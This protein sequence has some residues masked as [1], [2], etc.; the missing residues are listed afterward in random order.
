M[1]RRRDVFMGAT[2][3]KTYLAGYGVNSSFVVGCLL[4]CLLS[5]RQ[6]KTAHLP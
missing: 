3:L 1:S 2:S 4:P 6:W 5:W